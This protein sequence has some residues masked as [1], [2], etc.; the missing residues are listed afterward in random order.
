M[1]DMP[2]SK[3]TLGSVI[4]W[5]KK[6]GSPK[7]RAGM[8]R[9]G[10]PIAN[11]VGIPVGVLRAE[12][13]RIGPDHALALKLWKTGLFEAQ[14][15]ASMLGDPKLLTPAQMQSWCADFDNW[16]TVDTAYFTL[17]DRSAHSWKMVPKWVKQKSEFQKRA[18]FVLMACLAAHDKKT[19]AAAFLKLL[20]MIEKGASDE[21]NF[22]KKGVSWALRHIAHRNAA[23]HLA[24]MNTA[25]KLSKSD[26]PAERWVGK[27]A[28]RDITR[29]AVIAKVKARR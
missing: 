2:Q 29:P 13:K 9:Y 1:T 3:A 28:L 26:D 17:F 5:M 16:G 23:L 10:L 21:R 11:A 19:A 12:A 8:T 22:V 27:D 4:A 6:T 7:V 14:L 18:G 25:A 20:P 24:A 15:L